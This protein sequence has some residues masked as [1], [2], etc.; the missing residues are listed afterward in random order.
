MVDDDPM[1]LSML[2]DHLSKFKHYKLRTFSTGEEC[3]AHINEKPDII[4]LDYNLDNVD[5]NAK[6]GLDILI[7]L[8]DK[9]PA[10]DVIMLSAQD[11]IEVAVNTMKYG[12]FDYVIKNES[13]FLRIE[14]TIFNINRKNKLEK[15][16]RTYKILTITFFLMLLATIIL[17]PILDHYGLIAKVPGWA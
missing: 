7:E 14:N 3:L 4:I 15:E 16:A 17:F 12:A 9:V 10:T 5:K 1:Q 8:Q 11:K 6:D 2:Q 13:A